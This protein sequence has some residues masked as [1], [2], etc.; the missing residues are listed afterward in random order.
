M[1]VEVPLWE[2]PRSDEK[3]LHIGRGKVDGFASSISVTKRSPMHFSD[4]CQILETCSNPD[5]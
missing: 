4:H 5:E 2:K 3:K 1:V